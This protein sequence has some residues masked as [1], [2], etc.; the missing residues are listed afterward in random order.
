[1][2]RTVAYPAAALLL[3]VSAC[4]GP[5]NKDAELALERAWKKDW[6]AMGRS[7]G[8]LSGADAAPGVARGAGSSARVVIG[9]AEAYAGNLGGGV[10]RTV[11]E[12]GAGLAADFGL[13]GA[14]KFQLNLAEWDI[15]NLQ[16]IDQRKSGEDYVVR[17]RYDI[18]AVI[19]GA[20][21]RIGTDLTQSVR[22]INPGGDWEAIMVD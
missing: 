17:I 8:L 5:S 7:T 14:E 6:S 12:G 16:V 13:K 20:R 21:R 18:Y 1:M 4:S 22:L 3:L 11:I 10:A 9:A 15:T 2:K 19:G